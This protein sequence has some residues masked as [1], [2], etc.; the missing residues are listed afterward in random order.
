MKGRVRFLLTLAVCCLLL[1]GCWSNKELT[2]LAIISSLG[3]DV[4]NNGEYTT[5]MQVINPSNVAGGLQGGGGTEGPP[6]TIYSATGKNNVEMNRRVSLELSRIRYYAHTNLLVISEDLARK[7]G[8]QQILDAFERDEEFRMTAVLIIARG[9]KAADFVK[10]LTPIDKIPSNKIIKN[11]QFAEQQVGEALVM[12][13]QDVVKDLAAG[14]KEPIVTGF[15]ITGD[16]EKGI[17]LQDTQQTVPPTVIGASGLGIFKDGKLVDWLEG[18]AARGAVWILDKVQSTGISIDWMDQEK[19]VVYQVIRQNT[20][21]IPEIKNG[22]PKI[23]IKVEAEGNISE[24][25]VPVDLTDHHVLLAMEKALEKEIETGLMIAV[26]QAQKN[27]SD[28]FG[29]GEAIHRSNPKAWKKLK[30]EWH[31]VH[32]PETKVDIEVEVFIRRT[33]LRNK[34]YI[35]TKED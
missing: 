10:E 6:V 20:K 14:G 4:G 25:N 7:K 27:K 13:I 3:I 17:K 35:L 33:G 26:E 22:K 31:D 28:I 16:T 12:N 8:I 34:P 2:D 15:G 18:E 21:N 11:L 5:T 9:A 19:S 23:T 24:A 32:F 30:K 29:F 1:A